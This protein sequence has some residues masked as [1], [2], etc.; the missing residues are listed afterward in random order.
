[1]GK[2]VAVGRGV[3]VGCGVLVG[4]GV[5]VGSGV[6]VG[7]TGVSVAACTAATG[8]AGAAAIATDESAP[9]CVCPCAVFDTGVDVHVGSGV[10]V[11]A[12]R[13][14]SHP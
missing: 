4:K 6:A 8:S 7:G 9:D 2:G 12:I 11:G 1:M 14:V 13:P 5:A 10:R 3:A